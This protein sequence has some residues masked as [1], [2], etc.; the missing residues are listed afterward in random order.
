MQKVYLVSL[1]PK[2]R[3]FGFG[4]SLCNGLEALIHHVAMSSLLLR[5]FSSFALDILVRLRPTVILI[6]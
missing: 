1:K 4:S 6:T 3:N 2:T 5:L